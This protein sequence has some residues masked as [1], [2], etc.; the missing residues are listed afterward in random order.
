MQLILFI[1]FLALFTQPSSLKCAQADT[2]AQEFLRV[3]LPALNQKI[4]SPVTIKGEARLG[5]NDKLKEFVDNKYWDDTFVSIEISDNSGHKL[6]QARLATKNGGLRGPFVTEVSYG[7]P[8]AKNGLIK[9]RR[10]VPSEGIAPGRETYAAVTFKAVAEIPVVFTEA[11]DPRKCPDIGFNDYAVDEVYK[12]KIAPVDFKGSRL[13][14]QFRAMIKQQVKKGP[15]FAGHYTITT[16]DCGASCGL[17]AIVDDKTG[18]IVAFDINSTKGLR[19]TINSR[20]LITENGSAS[21][22]KHESER[23]FELKDGTLVRICQ[24]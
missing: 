6:G 14:G 9:I 24:Y 15:N 18:K 3:A 21:G 16:G 23:Y 4:L 22:L 5:E 20:L 11:A 19:Y 17:S 2:G 8:Y 12:G 13:A 7:R 1:A 10:A